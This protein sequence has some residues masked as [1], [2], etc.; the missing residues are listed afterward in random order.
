MAKPNWIVFDPTAGQNNGSSEL[1]I[2]AFTG[3]VQRQGVIIGTTAQGETSS[4]DVIQSGKP[5]FINVT[6]VTK[7]VIAL[8]ETVIIEGTSNSA[9]LK[10][11]TGSKV[12]DGVT[13][14][15]DVNEVHDDSWDGN[16]D[17]GIDGDPGASAEF[18]FKLNITVP[19]NKTLTA[20]ELQFTINNAN[21][22]VVS[23]TITITQAAGVKSYAVPVVTK[24]EYTQDVPAAGG[25][26]TPTVT[27]SQTWGWNG[28]T[29][30]GGTLTSGGTLAFTGT[31]VNTTTGSVSGV[32]LGTTE[33][34]RTLLATASVVVTMNGRS[35]VAKTAS[36]YQAANEAS[37]GDVTI[38]GGSAADIPASGGTISAAT[39]FTVAQ[40]VEYTS[41]ATRSGEVT[42]AFSAAVTAPSLST[43]VKARTK[44][45]T[46]TLTATGEGDV[47]ATKPYDVYQAANN[48]TEYG[49]VTHSLNSPIVLQAAGQAY[50]INDAAAA[51]QT[52]KYTSGAT[53]Q[54]TFT[55]ADFTV[56][57]KT[58]KE[59]FS[60]SGSPTT[61][62]KVTAAANPSA[63]P[64]NGFVVTVVIEG[65]GNKSTTVDI[66]FN[67]QGSASTILISPESS[68]F[69][70]TGGTKEITITSNDSWTLSLLDQ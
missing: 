2:D 14:S 64:R 6:N 35:S 12:I 46:L 63:D 38:T 56:T 50:N 24:I 5:E 17:T 8:G 40:T 23:D 70:A 7:A 55:F 67:Q 59:G 45:G 33:K 4:H 1:T 36:A 57:V 34:V 48:I 31:G 27:Y 20:R 19:E 39:G 47:T 44:V 54:H 29:T 32:S 16:T 49:N 62:Y 66:T 53:R 60:L 13:F 21:A 69:P 10:L 26:V 61:A 37:Y 15:L 25:S 22:S 65:E 30:N 43:T 42:T 41:G 3:R 28:N 68:T 11:A 9:N 58:A 51:K 18:S 52:M